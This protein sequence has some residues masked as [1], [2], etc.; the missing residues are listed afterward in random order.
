MHLFVTGTGTGVGKTRVTAL[1]VRTQRR[2]GAEAVGLKPIAAGDRDDALLLRE[3]GGN[4]LSLDEINPCH[5]AAPLAPQVA[6]R[7]EGRTIDF[8]AVNG[9]VAAARARFSHVAVEGVGGWRV[10]LAAGKTVGD[11]AREL[12]LPVLVV[13]SAGL[14]TLNHTLLT[15][16]AIRREGLPLLG[17]VLNRHGLAPGDRAAAT[18]REALEEWTGLP[19]VELKEGGELPEAAWLFGG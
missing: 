12:G 2:R 1:W 10:P 7:Q 5:L 16:E 19:I 14:G 18:N 15:I 9:A 13:A 3:A 6:A 8:A 17:I 11:W 4:L